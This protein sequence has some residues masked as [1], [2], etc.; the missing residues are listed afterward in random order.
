MNEQTS[1]AADSV[2]GF[3]DIRSG[4]LTDGAFAESLEIKSCKDDIKL[5]EIFNKK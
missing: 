2:S 4:V 3:Y 1:S 5:A